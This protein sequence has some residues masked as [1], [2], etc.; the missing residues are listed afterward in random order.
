MALPLPWSGSTMVASS[1]APPAESGLVSSEDERL[2]RIFDQ[3]QEPRDSMCLT[4]QARS[5]VNMMT[6]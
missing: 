3:S 1:S 6:M 2:P 5:P 4:V